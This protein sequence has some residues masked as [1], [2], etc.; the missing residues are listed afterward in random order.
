M[1][2][3]SHMNPATLMNTAVA[4]V[5]LGHGTIIDINDAKWRTVRPG[6]VNSRLSEPYETSRL[7]PA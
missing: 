6:R 2:D 3:N 1:L 4:S 5:D 7:S